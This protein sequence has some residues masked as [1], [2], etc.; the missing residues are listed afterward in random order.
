VFVQGRIGPLPVV[1]AG[2]L[3]V[4]EDVVLGRVQVPLVLDRA[5]RETV[6]PEVAATVVTRVEALRVAAV[7][8]LHAGG[9]LVHRRID[10]QVVVRGEER[11]GEE[12]PAEELDAVEEQM[13]KPAGS[14]S[15]QNTTAPSTPTVHTWK[16]PSGSSVRSWRAMKRR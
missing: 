13:E 14:W 9:E 5:A 12:V 11:E 7:E 15:S 2:R 10:D 6:A 16:R 3:R 4:A 8:V 1:E